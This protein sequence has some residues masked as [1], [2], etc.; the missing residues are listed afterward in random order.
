MR[1]LD[2]IPRKIPFAVP[3]GYFDGLPGRI[4]AR[5]GQSHVPGQ[6]WIWG[7]LRLAVAGVFLAAMG[8]YWYHHQDPLPAVEQVRLGIAAIPPDQ[9]VSFL[10]ENEVSTDDFMERVEWTMSDVASLEKQV[11]SQLTVPPA[12]V[13]KL[14][15]EFDTEL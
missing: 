8:V 6:A 2:D 5:T 11:Y 3:E 13:D 12:E 1:K 4:Q 7:T 15:D 14:M 9:L 10:D